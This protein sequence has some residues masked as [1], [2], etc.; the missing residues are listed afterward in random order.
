MNERNLAEGFKGEKQACDFLMKDKRYAIIAT[1]YRNKVGEIDI[2]ARDKKTLVFVEVKARSTLA[3]GRPCEAVD[4][5]KQQKIRRVAESYL[6]FKKLYDKVPVRFDV[7]EILGE[8]INHIEN[9][10]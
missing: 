6:I 8:K 3:F 10:F 1:N 9:A 7:I 5:R 4:Y 2:I